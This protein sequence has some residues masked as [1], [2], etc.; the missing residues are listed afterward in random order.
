MASLLEFLKRNVWVLVLVA[1]VVFYF[2]REQSGLQ[3]LIASQNTAIEAIQRIHTERAQEQDR[4]IKE[5]QEALRA[6]ETK[7]A[8][9][10][11]RLYKAKENT[12]NQIQ[13]EFRNDPEKVSARI[14]KVFGFSEVK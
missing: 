6:I 13:N 2:K 4:L 9:D 8:E 11:A 5:N 10:L 7:Y 1:G 3:D 14:T 12:K